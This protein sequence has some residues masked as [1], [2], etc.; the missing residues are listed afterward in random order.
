MKKLRLF[1]LPVLMLALVACMFAACDNGTTTTVEIPEYYALYHVSFPYY[2]QSLGIKMWN[3]NLQP[4][5]VEV[6]QHLSRLAGSLAE[7]WFNTSAWDGDYSQIK[8]NDFIRSAW[9]EQ[10]ANLWKPIIETSTAPGAGESNADYWYRVSTNSVMVSYWDSIGLTKVANRG[11]DATDINDDYYAYYPKGANTDTSGKKYPLIILCHGGGEAAAQ[12]E[13]WGFCQIAAKEKLF[14]LAPENSGSFTDPAVNINTYLDEVLDK[15]PMIDQTRIYITGSSMGATSAGRYAYANATR[16]AAVAP[17]DQPVSSGGVAS[18]LPD[19]L[20]ANIATYKMPTV[21]VGGLAD[22]YGLYNVNTRNYFLT[23]PGAWE[24]TD[25]YGVDHVDGWNRLMTAHGITGNNIVDVAARLANADAPGALEIT[26]YTGY[27][28]DREEIST[29]YG[30]KV[31]KGIFDGNE[32]LISY[33]VENRGHMPSGYDAN[34]IWDFFAQW[35]RVDGES[36]RN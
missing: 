1:G 8:V 20:A 2:D 25:I 23:H 14:L 11:A 7:N 13:S 3:G 19:D 12:V 36:V 29:V 34:L 15:Y 32:R 10:T 22:M 28:F 17:M 24:N 9:G 4:T 26:K 6:I 16:V 30:T 33:V 27:P 21:F 31:Y 5:L 18:N 35:R